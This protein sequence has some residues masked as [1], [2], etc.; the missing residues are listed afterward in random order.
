[1]YSVDTNIVIFN[2]VWEKRSNQTLSSHLL[3]LTIK[4]DFKVELRW[5]NLESVIQSKVR[6][7]EKNKYHILMHIYGI[8][9]NSTNEVCAGQE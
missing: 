1:M 2:V 8:S 4:I 6:Q 7:E 9:K 3:G 5:M